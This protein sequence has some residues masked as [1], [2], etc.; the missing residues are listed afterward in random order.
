MSTSGSKEHHADA[1]YRGHVGIDVELVQLFQ[2][3]VHG[4]ARAGGDAAGAIP[5][6][7][8]VPVSVR[9]LISSCTWSRSRRSSSNDLIF[10]ILIS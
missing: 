9:V 2:D 5:T 1:A 10:G 6:V 4:L 8:V 3:G 7:I